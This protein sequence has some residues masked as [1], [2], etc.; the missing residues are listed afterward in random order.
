MTK[1]ISMSKKIAD[2]LR[3]PLEDQGWQQMKVLLDR[4]MPES[5]R[6]VIWW[7]LMGAAAAIALL[8]LG[9]HYIS[10]NNE[11]PF[12]VENSRSDSRIPT[13]GDKTSHTDKV[14]DSESLSTS[15]SEL[16]H[17]KT[18]TA[19]TPALTSGIKNQNRQTKHTI[20]NVRTSQ[21]DESQYAD[22]KLEAEK[23]NEVALVLD[24]P[25]QR[26]ESEV[27]T[28]VDAQSSPES[29]FQRVTAIAGLTS[30]LNY[31]YPIQRNEWFVPLSIEQTVEV[32]RD[33][34]IDFSLATGML[35]DH[36]VSKPS[37]DLGGQ[38]R[39]KPSGK[40]ALGLGSFFWSINSD[41]TF[42]A[43]SVQTNALTDSKDF[44]L[45]AVQGASRADSAS[46]P[47]AGFSYYSGQVNHLAYW[48]VPVFIQFFPTGKWQPY[49]GVS[50]N[51]LLSDGSRGLLASSAS[52]DFQSIGSGGANSSSS[53]PI[54]D[55]VRMNNTAF[56][57]GLTF[58]THK[59][60]AIDLSY[61]HS[62]LSYLNYQVSE[63]DFDEYHRFLRLSLA[64]RF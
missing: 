21:Q 50:Q 42:S 13:E 63:G 43:V 64:Y 56:L 3:D 28:N 22:P 5:K 55:L 6:R 57:I 36:S 54:T 46:V 45:S 31:I 26:F 30:S 33:P 27:H 10:N 14:L 47:Q 37:F 12:L 32:R 18:E 49:V 11:Q 19:S 17:I 15:L 60:L 53:Q 59:H 34:R 16:E 48:R 23:G 4:E 39:L 58:Q 9:Y 62:K 1:E 38:I 2:R 35:T 20:G 24:E 41:Q 52:N 7:P 29:D 44:S 8:F 40:I 51:I 61:A 25:L